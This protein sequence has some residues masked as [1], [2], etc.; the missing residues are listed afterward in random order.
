MKEKLTNLFGSLGLILYFGHSILVGVLPFVMIDTS[1]WMTCLFFLIEQIF[2]L[3]TVFFWIWGL[4]CTIQGIQDIW[5]I[6]YYISFGVL[7]LPFFLSCFL[8]ILGRISIRLNQS[9]KQKSGDS[10]KP[11][12]IKAFLL[13]V[14]VLI[15]MRVI[16]ALP[17]A[18]FSAFLEAFVDPGSMGALSFLAICLLWNSIYAFLF[19]CLAKPLLAVLCKHTPTR[20]VSFGILG[21]VFAI[22]EFSGVVSVT[23]AFK[24]VETTLYL[25]GTPIL[26][27]PM[28]VSGIALGRFGQKINHSEQAE[29]SE[30]VQIYEPHPLDPVEVV[31]DLPE[32]WDG[33]SV[34]P[35]LSPLCTGLTETQLEF[36]AMKWSVPTDAAK[37]L[38]DY[39]RL[40]QN[41]PPIYEKT[42]IP[43]QNPQ[44][45]VPTAKRPGRYA[46]KKE[47]KPIGCG[48]CVMFLVAL[49][50][51]VALIVALP[52]VLSDYLPTSPTEP[53]TTHPYPLVYA[54]DRSMLLKPDYECICP[55]DV[56]V[57]SVAQQTNDFYVFLE[58]ICPFPY[59][60]NPSLVERNVNSGSKYSSDYD[61][62]IFTGSYVSN[63]GRNDNLGVFI[64]MSPSFSVD[65]PPGCYRLWYCFGESWYGLDHF[66]GDDTVWH[67]SDDI[68][69][70]Y[71]DSE[72][73]Y[74]QTI[75]L[76][77]VENG[78]M[79]T[80]IAKD[81]ELPDAL[82]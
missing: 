60:L 1:F 55:F 15:L 47:K 6:I 70:F 31:P 77:L 81:S 26:F 74:G 28:L 10:G 21:T 80:R 61:T 57:D 16:L 23:S 63:V 14:F 41:L 38:V 45:A 44:R 42:S 30:T 72:Y 2:P 66:F 32:I 37:K 59:G 78:N 19:Y 13:A 4:V 7:F 53:P 25:L 67:T 33:I 9:S 48:C 52:T 5:A 82:K 40:K 35:Y 17:S 64:N 73:V 27:I 56:T 65:V 46:K 29:S 69:T 22:T 75:T 68:L 43:D 3:A 58:Y 62:R 20:G 50:L 11:R 39:E 76:K 79:E 34:P 71:Y 12:P 18:A 24:F 36:L 54:S 51:G 49:A 8:D